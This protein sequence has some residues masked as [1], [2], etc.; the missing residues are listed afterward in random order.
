MS[1]I[2]LVN[3][4]K[5][6]G[7]AVVLT[8]VNADF[9]YGKII[10]LRGI[11][12]SGKTMLLRIIAGLIRPT[13]GSVSIDGLCLGKDIEFP[14]SIGLLIEN[15]AFL[16]TY[17]GFENLRILASIKKVVKEDEIQSLL[18]TVGLG[19]SI[20]KRY[21]KYSLGMKQRLGIAAAIME[22][23]KIVLL[24]EPTNA[25]DANGIK[26]LHDI[27]IKEKE[28]G[29]AVIVACHDA[30]FLNTIADEIYCMELGKIVQHILDPRS[31]EDI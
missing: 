22:K 24:D 20:D 29:A 1:D 28:R 10:G 21:K 16:N 6:I 11:N 19:K 15:P 13:A 7:N 4:E 3:I 9:T 30:G 27:I 26:L 18:D 2:Q 12:G 17:T 31:K 5:R 25:L 14:P 8:G 23:P